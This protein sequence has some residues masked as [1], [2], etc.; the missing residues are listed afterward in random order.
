ML[1][2]NMHTDIFINLKNA[3]KKYGSGATEVYALDHADLELEEGKICLI[4]GSSESGKSTLLNM[5]GDLDS[6][7][8]GELTVGGRRKSGLF[9]NQRADY[10]NE[11]VGFVFQFYNLIPDLTVEDRFTA[12]TDTDNNLDFPAPH[13]VND[14]VQIKIAF[15]H[16]YTSYL[17]QICYNFCV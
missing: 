16:F 1:R 13:I 11:D 7:D 6:L 2:Y 3:V 5:L 4:L 10:R 17:C 12:A 14:S 8:N 15:N 9:I